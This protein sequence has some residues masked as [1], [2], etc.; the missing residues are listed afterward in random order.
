MQVTTMLLCGKKGGGGGGGGE[1]STIVGH[2]PTG[3]SV[4]CG[5]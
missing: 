1:G 4:S 2:I 5:G 3:L